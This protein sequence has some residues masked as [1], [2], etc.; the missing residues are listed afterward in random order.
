MPTEKN[1]P[2][3]KKL[4]N[5]GLSCSEI[6]LYPNIPE[7]K[8]KKAIKAYAKDLEQ[9]DVIALLDDTVFGS[10]TEGMLI[11]ETHLYY[12][13]ILSS[14]FMI[15]YNSIKSIDIDGKTIIINDMFKFNA[16]TP[17]KDKLYIFYNT[18]RSHI[19]DIKNE[20][21]EDTT[22]DI[23]TEMA[24]S[25]ADISSAISKDEE[26]Y[27]TTATGVDSDVAKEKSHSKSE[28]EKMTNPLEAQEESD[29]SEDSIQNSSSS[30][31]FFNLIAKMDGYAIII[32]SFLRNNA[33]DRVLSIIERLPAI[34]FFGMAGR[35][36][37]TPALKWFNNQILAHG[38][39]YI[40]E[41]LV[42]NFKER[43]ISNEVLAQKINGA[44]A[45]IVPD[46]IRV[47]S[48]E[49]LNKYYPPE[50]LT[51]EA[52]P[53]EGFL[54]DIAVEK[55]LICASCGYENRINAKFCCNCGEK[56]EKEYICKNCGYKNSTPIKFCPECGTK[57]L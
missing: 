46:D 32:V 31:K 1:M 38:E 22:I 5:S 10:A 28:S 15:D 13:E 17:S 55:K 53:T 18:I 27:I 7:K 24:A 42:N 35:F 29:I 50:N 40:M 56:L 43:N 36:L 51:P 20:I 4:L 9:N 47:D 6:Y 23:S 19:D 48:L 30:S 37:L 54:E 44:P 52:C 39:P 11:T 25:E 49:L 12:H 57:F 26:I 2:L 14:P 8:L 33:P 41:N 21:I 16:T 45:S 3:H 34:G